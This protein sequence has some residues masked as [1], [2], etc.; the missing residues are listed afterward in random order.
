MLGKK[1][2]PSATAE[3]LAK[4]GDTLDIAPV[5]EQFKAAEALSVEEIK[6]AI[7]EI[8]E[9]QKT[10]DMPKRWGD[11]GGLTIASPGN[12]V[13]DPTYIP[14]IVKTRDGVARHVSNHRIIDGQMHTLTKDSREKYRW[15]RDDGRKIPIHQRRGYRFERYSQTFADT[16]LFTEGPGDT[17]KNGDL[18]LMKIYLGAWEKMR[19]EKLRLQSALEGNQGNELFSAGASAGVPTFK[20]NTKTGVR[21]MYT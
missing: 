16:G 19:E 2:K 14:E 5:V 11:R 12:I 6:A 20:E 13:D 21:E 10:P 9:V 3:K 4:G 17:V 15:C 18:L 7:V 1:K 8:D